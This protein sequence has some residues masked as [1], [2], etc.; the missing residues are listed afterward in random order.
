VRS[1]AAWC[2]GGAAENAR[3]RP[4]GRGQ[5]NEGDVGRRTALFSRSNRSTTRLGEFFGR[6]GA[7]AFDD[8]AGHSAKNAFGFGKLFGRRS[9]RIGFFGVVSRVETKIS[10]VPKSDSES[11]AASASAGATGSSPHTL[12]AR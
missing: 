2:A 5:R 8:V 11:F 6:R 9:A 1:R 12:A 4:S 3:I 10:F 7:G